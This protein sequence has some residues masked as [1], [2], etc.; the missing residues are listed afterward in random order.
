M[1][2]NY[3]MP[4]L[5]TDFVHTVLKGTIPDAIEALRTCFSG[6]TEPSAK[7]PYQFWA[8]TTTGFLKIRNAANTAWIT[9]LPLAA[10]RVIVP[11]TEFL[12]AS[13]S[14]TTTKKLGTVPHACTAKRLIVVCDTAST[15][16]SGNEW[17]FML[18]KRTNATPGTPVNL[19]SGTVGT[20]T[21]LSGVRSPAAEFV[22]YK[23][24]EFTP[25]QNATLEKD[26]LL[27]LV[28]TKAG[29]ATTLVNVM[30][31]VEVQ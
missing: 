21:A 17:Q 26:D 9:L 3:S 4:P 5:G 10:D 7:T 22:A 25:N 15:S 16:S 18:R 1:S 8:D 13:M 27:E 6:A 11:P 28:A 30:A 19:F 29:T 24:A 12:V 20:F 23:A 2:Q 31:Y 14:V